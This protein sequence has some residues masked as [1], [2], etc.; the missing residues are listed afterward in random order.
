MIYFD[1]AATSYPKPFSVLRRE[2][3][4]SKYFSFNSG[5]GGYAAS[6]RTAE[7]I[8]DVRCHLGKLFGFP[9]ERI[10]FTKNCTE[11]LNTA[12]K[13]IVKPGGH[14]IISSL[15]HNSV[16]RVV[17]ALQ[18]KGIADYDVAKYDP[19]EHVC[20]ANFRSAMKRNTCAVVCMHASNVFG[21]VFPIDAIGALC[22]KR[23]IPFIVDAAQSAGSLP[24]NAQKEPIDILCAPGHKGLMGPM[25]TGFLALREGI[26]LNPLTHGGTGSASLSLQQPAELPESLESGT[27]NNAGIL[28]LGQGLKFIEH[29]GINQIY[30]HEM[31]LCR[32]VYS[33]L[34]HIQ[35]VR[36]YTERPADNRNV[37]L[38]SFNI[39]NHS[40]EAVAAFLA[41]HNICVRGGYHCAYLAHRHFGTVKQGTVR[42]SFGCFNRE[43]ECER[44]VKVL[45]KFTF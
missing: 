37:P 34:H 6:L 20:V 31:Q 22:R 21:V 1:N 15:E 25:G 43:A 2:W 29:R 16:S 39:Q 4:A 44:F 14:L 36:L 24:I 35:A 3:I 23:G 5:R 28:A 18:D 9:P 11:A 38:I 19:D 17:Q 45:K 42:L 32:A 27:L 40:G 13:G 30:Q 12:I 10:I 8:Y 26:T 41:E 33:E 7:K